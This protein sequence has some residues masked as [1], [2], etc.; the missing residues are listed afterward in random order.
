MTASQ[1]CSPFVIRGLHPAVTMATYDWQPPSLSPLLSSDLR[2]QPYRRADAVRRS[3]RRRF[4]DQ[5]LRPLNNSEVVMWGMRVCDMGE[6]GGERTRG[7]EGEKERRKR[8]GRM[9][10]DEG[11]WTDRDWGRWGLGG[12]TMGN[13]RQAKC[14]N[15]MIC[16]FSVRIRSKCFWLCSDIV[17]TSSTDLIWL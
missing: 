3:V 15:L 2:N 12:H 16:F 13:S 5:N 9:P 10:Q 4:D 17:F 7:G 11:P 8:K 14:L 1:P 6:K